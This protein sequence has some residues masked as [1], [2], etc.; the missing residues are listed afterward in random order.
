MAQ[1]MRVLVTTLTACA[2]GKQG[3]SSS[4]VHRNRQH[5]VHEAVLAAVAPFIVRVALVLHAAAL[6]AASRSKLLRSWCNN[7]ARKAIM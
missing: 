5:L 1:T 2:G 7:D 4:H 3:P 6:G